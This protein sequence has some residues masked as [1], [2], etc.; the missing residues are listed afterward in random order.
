M[1][2]LT[3]DSPVSASE[4]DKK[5][6]WGE[7]EGCWNSRTKSWLNLLTIET[8]QLGLMAMKRMRGFRVVGG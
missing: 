1:R 6:R 4:N 2:R 5:R 8:F 3:L 7:K